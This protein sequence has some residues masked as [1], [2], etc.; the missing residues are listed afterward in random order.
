MNS[1]DTCFYTYQ[2]SGIP[3][4]NPGLEDVVNFL[5]VRRKDRRKMAERALP[6][7][8][9]PGPGQGGSKNHESTPCGDAGINMVEQLRFSIQYA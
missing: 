6:G 8:K 4:P 3:N 1:Y 5:G 7:L 2:T 9:N